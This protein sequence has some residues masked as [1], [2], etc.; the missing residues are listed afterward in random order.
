M[1]E[2]LQS[3]VLT[4]RPCVAAPITKT[5]ISAPSIAIPLFRA[6][7]P[8]GCDILRVVFLDFIAVLSQIKSRN[9]SSFVIH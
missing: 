7:T 9:N 4:P 8:G 1:E 3:L 2:R 5:I 6:T